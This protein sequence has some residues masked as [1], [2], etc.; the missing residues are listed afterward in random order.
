MTTF[1]IAFYQSNL[2]TPAS[3]ALEKHVTIE[4]TECQAFCPVV[5]KSPHPFI[6]KRVLPPPPPL[7][8]RGETLAGK[9]GRRGPNS[10][11]GTD[12]LVLSVYILLY[13]QLTVHLTILH[14][15]ILNFLQS[16]LISFVLFYIFYHSYPPPPP[17]RCRVY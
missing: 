16:F 15:F 17:H 7:S 6:R 12:T 1:R 11:E 14:S 2:S 13:N 10:D 8:P 4:Y 5:R 3:L 9:R